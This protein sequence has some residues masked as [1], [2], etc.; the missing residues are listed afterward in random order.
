M[1]YFSYEEFIQK[2][3][4]P[5][6]YNFEQELDSASFNALPTIN[7]YFVNKAVHNKGKNIYPLS[8]KFVEEM[9]MKYPSLIS[10]DCDGSGEGLEEQL[11][12]LSRSI[13]R[14]LWGW[15]DNFTS[16]DD[17]TSKEVKRYA[18]TM[19]KEFGLMGPETMHSAQNFI[20]YIADMILSS[21]QNEDLLSER[22]G[23][24][25]IK[26]LL[27]LFANENYGPRLVSSLSAIENLIEFLEIY[28]TMGN[29]TLVPAYL[30]PFRAAKV[31]DYWHS[32]LEILKYK[33]DIWNYRGKEIYWNK[34]N[35][36]LYANMFYMWDYFNED[37]TLKNYSEMIHNDISRFLHVMINKIKRRGIFMLM[38]LQVHK[39][40]GEKRFRILAEQ[41]FLKQEALYEGYD[42]VIK[43]MII[44]MADSDDGLI[45]T[46]KTTRDTINQ[47]TDNI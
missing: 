19:T 4:S 30:N 43:R 47:I 41:L 45:N 12:I 40:I 13:Y 6:T 26:F 28:H 27:E 44:E 5:E 42:D 34:K 9:G 39:H 24:I 18:E 15:N 22:K 21:T 17:K 20:N 33:E 11:C 10:F 36:I 1:A 37:G 31:N 35:F 8:Y 25:S 32:T 2:N 3:D 46:I 23:N 38:M 14:A 29:F 16:Q 7:R